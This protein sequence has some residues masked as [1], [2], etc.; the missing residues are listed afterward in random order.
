MVPALIGQS[1]ATPYDGVTMRGRE[2][3]TNAQLEKGVMAAVIVR[4]DAPWPAG[5][6][7]LPALDPGAP[8]E[9]EDFDVPNECIV[10]PAILLN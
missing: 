2:S 9:T 10:I 3:F 5:R 8:D 4:A 1:C 6:L 7:V